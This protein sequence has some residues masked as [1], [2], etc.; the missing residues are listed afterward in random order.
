MYHYGNNNCYQ[1]TQVNWQR[2]FTYS[3]KRNLETS[4]VLERHENGNE[5]YSSLLIK[6]V[7]KDK[8]HPQVQAS[9]KEKSFSLHPS[10][11]GT[12]TLLHNRNLPQFLVIFH[13]LLLQFVWLLWNNSKFW[14]IIFP[15]ILFFIVPYLSYNKNWKTRRFKLCRSLSG[16]IQILVVKAW[17]V[18]ATSKV[19]LCCVS[20]ISIVWVLISFIV[21]TGVLYMCS[22]MRY[23]KSKRNPIFPCTH[24]LVSINAPQ[25]RRGR[26]F[27]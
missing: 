23:Q 19:D 16:W 1:D 5:I 22:L 13:N 8:L 3:Y 12:M 10:I 6:D 20:F 11:Y 7:L 2:L 25:R 21:K 14:H 27:I 26:H 4:Q 15:M 18:T 9:V 24:V 17:K